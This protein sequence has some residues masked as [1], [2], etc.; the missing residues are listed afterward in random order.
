[1]HV[2]A[3]STDYTALESILSLPVGSE[4]GDKICVDVLIIDDTVVEE[5]EQFLIHLLHG[6]RLKC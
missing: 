4:S 3:A 5:T 6:S 2:Y 1:M